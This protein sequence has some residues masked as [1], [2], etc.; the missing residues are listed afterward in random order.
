MSAR[1]K[2]SPELVDG[3]HW[4]VVDTEIDLLSAITNWIDEF[5]SEIGERFMVEIVDMTDEEVALLPEV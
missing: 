3:D 1:F 5:G 2:I 4:S